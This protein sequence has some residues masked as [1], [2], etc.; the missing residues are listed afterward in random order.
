MC[1]ERRHQDLQVGRHLLRQNQDGMQNQ[2]I[3]AWLPVNSPTARINSM[4]PVAGNTMV[5][6]T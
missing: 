2:L 5:S 3:D 6:L 1:I 4:N